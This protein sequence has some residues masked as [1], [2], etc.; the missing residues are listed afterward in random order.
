LR[1]GA[2]ALALCAPAVVYAAS[3][4]EQAG[5]Q[6]AYVRHSE[7]NP[8][9]APESTQQM[10]NDNNGRLRDMD[11]AHSNFQPGSTD[12]APKAPDHPYAQSHFELGAGHQD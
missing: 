5:E 3:D 8:A 2:F 11:S 9:T 1:H 10:R 6:P 4:N 7:A 12:T